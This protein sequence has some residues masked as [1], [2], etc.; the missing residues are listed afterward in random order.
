MWRIHAL[1]SLLI[2]CAGGV[3]TRGADAPAAPPPPAATAATFAEVTVAPTRTSIY[4]GSVSLSMPVF[5]REGSRY[6][7]T[8]AAKA[9]PYFFYNE[10]GQLHIELPD[11]D[12]ARLA[13]GQTVE[14]TGQAESSRGEI[15]RIEGRATPANAREGKIKV[16]VFVTRKIELIFNTTYRFTGQG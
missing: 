6:Q 2:A 12:L 9:F 11:A 7:S 15:R 16:R 3:G 14:F 4:V 13:Q 8:Y 10:H 5:R 1:I